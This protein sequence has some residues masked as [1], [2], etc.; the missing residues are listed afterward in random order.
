MSAP[1]KRYPITS[2]GSEE[3]SSGIFYAKSG[4]MDFKFFVDHVTDAD[5]P[6]GIEY[7]VVESHEEEGVTVID[8]ARLLSLSLRPDH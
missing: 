1:E 2:E 5:I 3:T 8:Q 7:E 4:I 6:S